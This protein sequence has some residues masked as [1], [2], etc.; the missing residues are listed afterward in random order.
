MP[1]VNTSRVLDYL[2]LAMG[3]YGTGPGTTGRIVG[4]AAPIEVE[5]F[6]ATPGSGFQGTLYKDPAT[7]KYTV[8][9]AGT[10][11]LTDLLKSDRVLAT[12]NL[13]TA[14]GAGAW[15]PQMT[16][17]LKFTI[18]SFK[19]IQKEYIDRKEEPPSIDDLRTMVT[20]T[21]HSLGG[22]LAELA[23]KFFGLPGA[24]IDGPGISA[25]TSQ[26][27]Y[28][29]LQN[30]A[31]TAFA[32]M[33]PNYSLSGEQFGAYAY[34]VVGVAGTHLDGI[35]VQ[36][37]PRADA[38][39][40]AMFTATG[41][42]LT[43]NLPAVMLSAGVAGASALAHPSGSILAETEGL[44]GVSAQG[45]L[46]TSP[47]EMATLLQGRS[48]IWV[49][50]SSTLNEKAINA[51]ARIVE[52][53]VQNG[54]SPMG[55]P[56][57]GSGTRMGPFMAM[58]FR[59]SETGQIKEIY[60]PVNGAGEATGSPVAKRYAVD[61]AGRVGQFD[62][63]GK[64][65]FVIHDDVGHI[66]V[67]SVSETGQVQLQSATGATSDLAVP[68][69]IAA[70]MLAGKGGWI[71]TVREQN[72][73]TWFD[74]SDET[75]STTVSH[76]EVRT[77]T[78][79]ETFTYNGN[80]YTLGIL[81]T[82]DRKI[83]GYADW[84]ESRDS[85]GGGV[86]TD[87][88]G[89][90]IAQLQ[91]GDK[92]SQMDDGRITINDDAGKAV[93]RT[94][95]ETFA[96]AFVTPSHSDTS[97]NATDLHSS[98]LA[99]YFIGDQNSGAYGVGQLAGF[100][101]LPFNENSSFLVNADGDIT[102][103]IN[104]LPNGY[105]QVKDLGGNAVYVSAKDASVLTQDQ[106]AQAQ[107]QALNSA[108][109]GQAANAVSLMNSIIGLQHWDGMSDLQRTAVVASIYNAV[110][111]IAGDALPGDLGTAASA[112][113]LL[114]ALDKG[115]VGSVLISSI[116][117]IN[118]VADG[119]ASKAIG[120]ALGMD[121]SN[122]VP[123]LNLV[124]ALDSGDPMSILAAAANFIPVYGQLI[125][126]AISVFGSLLEDDAPDIPTREG[127]AHAQWDAAGNIV[128][129]TDQD[130]EGGGPTA[131]G[132][133]TSMV[134]GLQAQLANVHDAAGNPYALVPDLLPSIGF[135]YDPDGLNLA[136]GTKGFVFQ[137]WTDENGQTQTRYYDGAGNRSDG[138]GETLAGDFM[139]HAAGAI[140]PAWA[141]ATALAHYQQGQGIHLPS[142][143]AGLPQEAADGLHQ[144]LQAIT[145]ALP[146][147]PALQNALID[148][149]G[150]S[151]LERT[152]WLATNQQILAIDAD[153]N[154]QIGVNEL[155]SLDG[156]ASLH[157]LNWLD[158]NNDQILNERDPAF[159]ALRLWMDLHSDADSRGEAS[160]LAQAG[161]IAIDFGSNPPTVVHADG[162][163]TALTV[164]TLT[165]DVL[166]VKY[167][168]VAGGVLQL[169]EQLVGAPTAI[170]HAVNTRQFDGQAEHIHGGGVDMDGGDATVDAGDNRLVTTSAHTLAT[171]SAQ[172]SATLAAGDARIRAGA[173]GSAVAGL[174]HCRPHGAGRRRRRG[175]RHRAT[176][177][178]STN[179]SSALGNGGTPVIQGRPQMKEVI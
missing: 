89:N 26:A 164:Q 6:K 147:E 162:S 82:L 19:Q 142:A 72:P 101:V 8:S 129:I 51:D 58:A 98:D 151:Y 24:N 153:G 103:E 78:N 5:Q 45:S 20:V 106:Y 65:N 109:A 100:D 84:T 59:D 145:L 32:G 25:S 69:S 92:V 23:A 159:A 13:L 41:G 91:P 170:L 104:H 1:I 3:A 22:S 152:Q 75:P 27:Q 18:E 107:A 67:V 148:V 166:G 7:G 14:I 54:L 124:L 135:R 52:A 125:S 74:N 134:H 111:K 139:Q 70:D 108:Q 132:W 140:A 171:Q 146:Q 77:P 55:L 176:A 50:Y 160:T 87:G 49:G 43:G 150:D 120:N 115:D 88:Q 136:N 114:N 39:L 61:E 122:V 38:A 149:D 35:E 175:Y 40:V 11:D 34:T 105:Y 126:I 172:S 155:L 57:D 63:E 79:V 28:S 44:A 53:N 137:T 47:Y 66:G 56:L 62:A 118:A 121:P 102:A 165:G 29:A 4:S 9:F 12:S 15:D 71:E 64:L 46:P 178:N 76:P 130:I 117:L 161:I 36:R 131:T 169:D 37:T 156:P 174:R 80:I 154:N 97:F 93:N 30:E 81:G 21:G 112:L 179:G 133:M 10:N 141:V 128:V 48:S 158:A 157:S 127:L 31:Q 143:D 68:P 83:P 144:T 73:I 138:T 33:Q 173:F 168:A 177:S 95:D 113:G 96:N 2:P 123:G 17:A 42:A 116:S 119:M 167:E 110:D 16:D 90:T 94:V 99:N 163:R 86:I 85:T 60:T